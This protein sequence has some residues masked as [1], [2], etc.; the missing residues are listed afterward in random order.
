MPAQAG[1]RGEGETGVVPDIQWDEGE[2]EDEEKGGDGTAARPNRWGRRPRGPGA[3]ALVEA[4]RPG[5]VARSV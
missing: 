3:K 2:G 1:A 4:R 5:A